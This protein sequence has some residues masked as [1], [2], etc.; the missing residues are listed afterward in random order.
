METEGVWAGV[1]TIGV[2]AAE[3]LRDAIPWALCIL[4]VN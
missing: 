4:T 1:R 3:V 2:L